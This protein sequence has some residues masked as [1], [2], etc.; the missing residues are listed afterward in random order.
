MRK[1]SSV[2]AL[3]A[4]LGFSVAAQAQDAP[5][6]DA[7]ASEPNP[8]LSLGE[9]VPNDGVGQAYVK[10]AFNEWQLRCIRAP[11]GQIDPCQLYQLVKDP[12][13]NPVSE[14]TLFALQNQGDA[15]AGATVA[16]PL[17]TLLN[18][19]LRISVDGGNAKQYPFTFCNPTGCFVRLGLTANDVAAFKRGAAATIEIVPLAA[20][21]ERVALQVSLS[22]FTAAY[23]AMIATSQPQ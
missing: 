5:A 4:I 7:P 20:P 12:N 21:T 1:F 13:G 15:V 2:L 16:T 3:A 6:A 17:E 19:P 10:E 18:Q 22:G 23:D 8:T 11:E 14:F 9:E